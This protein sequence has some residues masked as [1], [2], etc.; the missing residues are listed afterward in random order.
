M[1]RW[2]TVKWQGK[3][4]VLE[5]RLAYVHQGLRFPSSTLVLPADVDGTHPTLAIVRLYVYSRE[6]RMLESCLYAQCSI[7]RISISY[8]ACLC[9][10]ATTPTHD[11]IQVDGQCQSFDGSLAHAQTPSRCTHAHVLLKYLRVL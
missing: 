1:S 9:V 2:S 7:V 4:F 11:E 6:Q 3:Y 8:E 10:V 5:A